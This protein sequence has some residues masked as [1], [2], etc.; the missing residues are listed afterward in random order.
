MAASYIISVDLGGTKILSALINQQ[1]EIVSRV[2]IATEIE[3]GGDVIVHAIVESVKQVLAQNNL[4]QSDIKALCMGVPGTVNP[5]TGIIAAAP[6]LGLVEFNIKESLAS[7]LSIPV[8][9]ENDVNLAGLGIKKYELK[10]EVKNMIVVFVGTGIGGALF[11][12]GKIYRGSTF[13]AGEIGHMLV[14]SKGAFSISP[15]HSTFELTAS[16]TAI[17]REIK[18][19]IIKGK[20]SIL[21]DYSKSKK[22][23]KSK[24][25][26]DALKKEDPVVIKQLSKASRAIGTVLGSITT[27]LNIDT[28]VLG[29]GVI[30]A[31]HE[32]MVPIITETFNNSVL[33]APG[34][35]VKIFETKL[36]DDAALYGGIALTE[37]FLEAN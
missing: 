4:V 8:L 3:K 35:C 2:K 29:G 6:N 14:D 21:R 28:I 10:D 25:L 5:Y 37:E 31:M 22:P 1:N 19:N 16:R 9:I 18:K 36:G 17:V 32:F 27:L 12:D 13:Y 30:E 34:K 33:E 23:I 26:L 15:I 11:F 24:V 20:N 7:Q